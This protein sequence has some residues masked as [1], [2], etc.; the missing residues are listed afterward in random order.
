MLTSE[1][2]LALACVDA[3]YC[4]ASSVT[5]LDLHFTSI[6]SFKFLKALQ[7]THCYSY[8]IQEATTSVKTLI[9]AKQENSKPNSIS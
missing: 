8:Y 5:H 3:E 2:T 9:A 4:T 7:A 6:A 1:T